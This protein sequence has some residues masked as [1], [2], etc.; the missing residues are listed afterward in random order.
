MIEINDEQKKKDYKRVEERGGP[1]LSN[2]LALQIVSRL[3]ERLQS[4]RC[5][6]HDEKEWNPKQSGVFLQPPMERR[7][8]QWS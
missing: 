4:K 5:A 2:L 7:F 6:D 1:N 8:V 3:C